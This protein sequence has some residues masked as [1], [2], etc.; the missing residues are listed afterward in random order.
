[1]LKR[2]LSVFLLCVV[3]LLSACGSRT[4][5]KE[6]SIITD[7]ASQSHQAAPGDSQTVP[8]PLLQSYYSMQST[9]VFEYMQNSS[10]K[11]FLAMWVKEKTGIENPSWDYDCMA[12]YYILDKNFASLSDDKQLY[13]LPFSDGSGRNGY[14][15]IAY[16]AD[17]P[18]ISNE[19]VAETTPYS[20]DFKAHSG[21]IMENLEW[22]ALI[23]PVQ[24][25][26]ACL[27]SI[28]KITV[29]TRPFCLPT[30]KIPAISVI[31][32]ILILQ[33]RNQTARSLNRGIFFDCL[34]KTGAL[35][36]LTAL[37][38]SGRPQAPPADMT[39]G[40]PV[41]SLANSGI[42]SS[43]MTAGDL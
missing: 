3:L 23:F 17:G 7:E 21:K 25:L 26:R 20:Y 11:K 24:A 34:T 9:P 43:K 18:A 30:G 10:I 37:P 5:G 33:S 22:Q 35:L 28:R 19:G 42:C 39:C 36:R 40:I 1:M 31:W 27:W 8:E 13:S 12:Q 38:T 29:Q 32:T 41:I 14:I 4:A 2:I 6:M 15:V 16:Y